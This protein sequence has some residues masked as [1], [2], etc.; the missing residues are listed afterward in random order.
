MDLFCLKLISICPGNFSC[1]ISLILSLIIF[2]SSLFL[3]TPDI[4][5]VKL[6]DWS[7]N[8]FFFSY[9]LSILFICKKVSWNFMYFACYQEFCFDYLLWFLSFM[10]EVFLKCLKI[11]GY[12]FIFKD[13]ALKSWVWSPG[14]SS[15]GSILGWIG[16]GYFPQRGL[17]HSFAWR[18]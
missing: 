2:L 12:L 9:L 10:L 16:T 11:L 17:L 15:V 6:L 13:E 18:V 1:M 7:S 3:G 5:M 14:L 4:Q 8:F